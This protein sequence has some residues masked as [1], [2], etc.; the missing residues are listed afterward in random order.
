MTLEVVEAL[1]YVEFVLN[2]IEGGLK[3]IPGFR[4]EWFHIAHSVPPLVM[5]LIAFTSF[6]TLLIVSV[7]AGGTPRLS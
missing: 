1:G 2:G 6:F 5:P 3:V 7:G 4:S